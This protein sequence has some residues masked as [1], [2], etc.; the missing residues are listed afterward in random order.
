MHSRENCGFEI[1]G[2]TPLTTVD[3][4]GRLAAVV[5]CQ[6]CPW[7]CRYCQNAHLIAR[8]SKH[9]I[10][11][12]D[13]LALLERRQGLLD[14]VVFSGGEP[15]LQKNLAA[16][17]REAKS[18]GFETGLHTGGPYPERLA[19]VLSDVDWVGIDIKGPEDAYP[20]LTQAGP[21]S[22]RKAW[23]SLRVVLKGNVA[24][25]VRTTVHSRLLDGN[26]LIAVSEE[27]AELGVTHYVLQECVTEHCPDEE[28]RGCLTAP[29]LDDALIS[30]I[31]PLFPHFGV[32]RA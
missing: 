10:A 27:L 29:I 4:P 15:T 31:A 14:G 22:G 13:V 12:S 3:F 1:G 18:L 21:I 8:Q 11:W 19:A 6:G 30:R 23:E 26:M 20:D 9:P 5:F 7:R 24:H 32:R 25:E 16:K 2:F 17:L 28:L